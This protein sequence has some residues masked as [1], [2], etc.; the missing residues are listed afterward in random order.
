[1]KLI[2]KIF[3]GLIPSIQYILPQEVRASQLKTKGQ[4]SKRKWG[5]LLHPHPPSL[6]IDVARDESVK[7]SSSR[8]A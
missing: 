7:G 1:M 8:E 4:V 2:I 5:F 6:Y 3:W